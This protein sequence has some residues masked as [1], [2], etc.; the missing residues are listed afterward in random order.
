[1]TERVAMPGDAR[2]SKV[3]VNFTAFL[4]FVGPPS[5]AAD[6]PPPVGGFGFDWLR[7]SSARCQ[8]VTQQLIKRLRQCEKRS[9]AFGRSDPVY[10]CT[11]DQ[12][13]EYLIFDTRSA[14]AANL[15]AMKAH[16]P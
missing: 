1:V 15:E 10:V 16:A 2:L 8:A 5:I 3:L 7:P 13:S 6:V 11:V 14:C 12:R 4:V 9:G